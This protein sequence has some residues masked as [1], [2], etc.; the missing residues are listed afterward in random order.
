MVEA[1]HVW[2]TGGGVTRV[3]PVGMIQHVEEFRP[4]LELEALRDAEVLQQTRIQIPE[5]RP[6]DDVAAITLLSRRGDAEIRLRTYN[7]DTVKVWVSRILD[8]LAGVIHHG[9]LHA[10]HK[11]HVALV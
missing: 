10:I 2:R 9:A 5:I 4:E 6:L 1:L 11:L 8:A 7:A 3:F